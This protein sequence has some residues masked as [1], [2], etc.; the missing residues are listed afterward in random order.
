MEEDKKKIFKKWHLA[1]LLIIV[2]VCVVLKLVDVFYW[3]SRV[4]VIKDQP[5][6][7]LIANTPTHWHKG[8][9]GRNSLGN[10]QGM[11]FQYS[12]SSR[13]TMVMRDMNFPI[14]I[15][16]VSDGL[17]VDMAPNVQAEPGKSEAELIRY[18]P[19]QACNLVIELEAGYIVK[20]GLKIGDRV[21]W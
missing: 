19:R 8:L 3:P 9:G 4:I 17:I 13:H 10:Y 20:N 15:I 2:F 21:A 1:V 16:W 5:V 7:V 11:A 14:D 12:G 18:A 6:N